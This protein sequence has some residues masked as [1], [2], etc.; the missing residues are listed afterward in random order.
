MRHYLGQTDIQ[1]IV[2]AHEQ[3]Q[4]YSITVSRPGDPGYIDF[5][6]IMQDS[7]DAARSS[8]AA[9]FETFRQAL[10][11]TKRPVEVDWAL[12]NFEYDVV[13]EKGVNLNM[14]YDERE[15]KVIEARRLAA[16]RK[17]DLEGFLGLSWT[18]W[19]FIGAGA[20]VGSYVVY[21]IV[22]R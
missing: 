9:S 19:A 15:A 21:R 5:D 18:K 13:V 4:G 14:I 7:L 16:G 17:A 6:S 3:G 2:S 22:K 20:L 1:E 11:V 12:T 10:A 8:L